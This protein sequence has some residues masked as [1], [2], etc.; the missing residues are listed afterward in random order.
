MKARTRFII[1]FLSPAL[2]LYVGLVGL[3]LVQSFYLS[4]FNWRATSNHK[5]FVGAKNLVQYASDPI[6]ITAGKNQALLLVCGGLMIM[7]FAVSIAHALLVPSKLSK[8]IQAIMLFPQVVSMVV[9]GVIWQF[10]LHPRYGLLIS[11][12][13][14][15]HIPIPK[16]GVLG[17]EG[18]AGLAVLLAFVWQA[19]GFYVMLFGAGLR[20]I[21]GEVIEAAELDGAAGWT[22]FR[23]ITWPLLWSVKRVAVIYVVSN[24]MG[25]FALVQLLTNAG[26]DNATQVLLT[27]MFKKGWEQ[28]KMGQASAIAVYSFLIAMVLGALVWR[29]IGRN[30]EN[31]RRSAAI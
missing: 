8:G 10:M 24:V 2:L 25:T 29:V 17:V 31:P 12:C 11:A 14:Y 5:T 16:D 27:Y 20:N 3:P 22:R 30:P 7:M 26:P 1:G 6:M 15:A 23:R 28:N 19:I 13:R 9:V 4:L 18:W 21:D